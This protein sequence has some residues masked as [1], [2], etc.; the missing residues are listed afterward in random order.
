VGAVRA[1]GQLAARGGLRDL[2]PPRA[3]RD[4]LRVPDAAARLLLG[5]SPGGVHAG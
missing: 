2:E 1:T 4:A 5:G 3:P